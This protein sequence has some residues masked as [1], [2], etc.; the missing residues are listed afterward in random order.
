MK[1]ILDG[2]VLVRHLTQ[3]ERMLDS[4]LLATHGRTA[5][6]LV[7]DGP[8]R[9]TMMGIA[10]GGTLP[11]HRTDAHVTIHQLEGEM[12]F[13]ARG[14]QYPMTTGDVLVL[15]PGVEHEARSTTGGVFLLTVVLPSDE[16]IAAEDPGR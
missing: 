10:A 7:K 12:M 16:P 3:D 1:R 14:R 2:E 13:T 8:L 15:A 9:L 6:T 4:A 5:R 11:M